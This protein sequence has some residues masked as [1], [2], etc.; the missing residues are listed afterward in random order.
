MA[1]GSQWGDLLKL[2]LGRGLRL[3]LVGLVIGSVG[4]LVL[5]RILSSLLYEVE[6]TSIETFAAPAVALLVIVLIALALPM[7]RLLK[8][9]P[10]EGLRYE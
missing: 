5:G 6:P 4:G 10:V 7:F 8:I 2:V 3:A 9:D 1:F